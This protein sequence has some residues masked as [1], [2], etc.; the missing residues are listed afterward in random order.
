MLLLEGGR[1]HHHHGNPFQHME[2]T[3]NMATIL[4]PKVEVIIIDT[5]DRTTTSL[6]EEN[7][8]PPTLP[9]LTRRMN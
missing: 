2:T 5:L 6:V 7:I 3:P 1:D 4:P 9:R 8:S